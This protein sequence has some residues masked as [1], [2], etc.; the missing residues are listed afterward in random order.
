MKEHYRVI[1]RYRTIDDTTEYSIFD[2]KKPPISQQFWPYSQELSQVAYKLIKHH[3]TNYPNE[4]KIRIT[5]TE[6]LSS[7]IDL[8]MREGFIQRSLDKEEMSDLVKK[9]VKMLPVRSSKNISV[10]FS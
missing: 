10:L 8:D 2:I 1:A 7:T 6:T 4:R 9:I 3:I 5:S